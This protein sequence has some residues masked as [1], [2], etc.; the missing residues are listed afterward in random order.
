[1]KIKRKYCYIVFLLSM[2]LFISSC[3]KSPT[4]P[5]L[6]HRPSLSILL[7][8]EKNAHVIIGITNC[9]VEPVTTLVNEKLPAGTHHIQWDCKDDDGEPVA[10]GVYYCY[11]Y[12]EGKPATMD[13]FLLVK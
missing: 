8:L 13:Q 6:T 3:S 12:I 4:K 5:N 10:S 11:R 7:T 1:V 9:N 2:L